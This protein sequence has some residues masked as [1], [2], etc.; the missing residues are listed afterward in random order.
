VNTQVLRSARTPVDGG[1]AVFLPIEVGVRELD[2]RLLL[3]CGLAEMGVTT[4]MG[5]HDALFKAAEGWREGVYV[6]KNM[7]LTIFPNAHTGR[8]TTL[9]G[10]GFRFAHLDE[11]GAVFGGDEDQWR[12]MLDGRLDPSVLSDDDQVCTWGDFQA[13]HYS[14]R[15]PS[16]ADR[17]HV[18]G[19]PRFDVYRTPYRTLYES[20]A[21]DLRNRYGQFVLANTSFGFANSKYSIARLWRLYPGDSSARLSAWWSDETQRLAHMTDALALLAAERPHTTI[22][23]RPHPAEDRE[24]YR[25]L[26]RGYKNVIVEESS[27]PVAPWLLAASALVHDGCTTAIEAALAGTPIVTFDPMSAKTGVVQTPNDFGDRC[28]TAG[29]VIE[30]IDRALAGRGVC[31]PPASTRMRTLLHN[32]HE[33]AT[34]LVVDVVSRMAASPGPTRPFTVSPHVGFRADLNRR[35]W[36]AERQ[37]KKTVSSLFPARRY[38]AYASAFPGFDIP[39]TEARLQEVAATTSARVQFH[40]M[41]RWLAAVTPAD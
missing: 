25:V 40:P 17:V 11:E 7:F 38:Q 20:A 24:L 10:K 26:F 34:P 18:T 31:G 12:W 27:G 41:G 15:C 23:L 14:E 13:D 19:H 30:G 35:R 32:L 33:S 22:V 3:A 37:V 21:V 36:D 2:S 39:S 5:Q 28:T 29:Q 16:L 4:V 6:G 9:K 1:R 8:Y